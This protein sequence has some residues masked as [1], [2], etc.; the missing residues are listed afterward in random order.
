MTFALFLLTSGMPIY[1]HNLTNSGTVLCSRFSVASCHLFSLARSK[2]SCRLASRFPSSLIL[3]SLFPKA[4][5]NWFAALNSPVSFIL[6]C[7]CYYWALIPKNHFLTKRRGFV[8][9]TSIC[10]CPLVYLFMFASGIQRPPIPRA[11][12]C[13]QPF[14]HIKM[15]AICRMCACVVIPWT[16]PLVHPFCHL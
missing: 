11:S 14:K 7:F 3:I 6:S 5:R 8:S 4:R 2:R 9:F 16:S 12:I 10:K 13:T 15:T 1:P